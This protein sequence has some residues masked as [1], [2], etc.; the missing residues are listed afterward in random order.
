MVVI[1]SD[2]GF[3]HILE[4]EVFGLGELSANVNPDHLSIYNHIHDII[5]SPIHNHIHNII[6]SPI[7]NYIHNNNIIN[8]LNAAR[9]FDI[10]DAD[11][12]VGDDGGSTGQFDTF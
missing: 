12:D 1:M 6:N 4:V 7:H 10:R 5:N 3:L 8:A 2:N 9:D 11:T